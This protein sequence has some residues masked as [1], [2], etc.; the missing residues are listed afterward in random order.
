VHHRKEG[1]D[2][3]EELL[4]RNLREELEERERRHFSSKDKSYN[5]NILTREAFFFVA[6]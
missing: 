4:K 3:K 6:L 5:G 1:Q 2:T